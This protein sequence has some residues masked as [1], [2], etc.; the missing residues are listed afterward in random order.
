MRV[1]RK[2]TV[3]GQRVL[4]IGK[5]IEATKPKTTTKQPKKKTTTRKSPS[6]TCVSPAETTKQTA[7]NTTKPKKRGQS[8]NKN[9]HRI[10]LPLD[11]VA[12]PL[13]HYQKHAK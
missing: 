9:T 2:Y 6:Q 5:S 13:H 12:Y 11:A 1:S 7:E 4:G 3:Q 10:D 8:P